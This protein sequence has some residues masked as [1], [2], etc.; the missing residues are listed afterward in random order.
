MTRDEMAVL[1]DRFIEALQSRDVDAIMTVLIDKCTY[2]SP[3]G[4][5][6]KGK[7]AIEA[8]YRAWFEA[9]PDLQLQS[10]RRLQDG[11][12]A[13]V[14]STFTATHRGD[15]FGMAG[16]GKRVTFDFLIAVRFEGTG[17]AGLRFFYDFAAALV[18]T[19]ALKV[20]PV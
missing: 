10:K 12:R 9:F 3:A 18:K 11:H 7:P 13:V 4:G 2:E 5:H 8:F 14:V 1:L 17:I 16:T 20:K 15:L 19:G 6:L